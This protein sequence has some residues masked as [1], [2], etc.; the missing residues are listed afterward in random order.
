MRKS[1]KREAVLNFIGSKGTNGAKF[2][3]IQ[4]FIVEMN[5]K[6]YDE[7]TIATKWMARA[8]KYRGYWC[9]YLC[10]NNWGGY[11]KR[12]ILHEFCIKVSNKHYVLKSKIQSTYVQRYK[13]MAKENFND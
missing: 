13:E 11:K 6:N 7:F 2:S 9:D 12:G 8:R 1:P 5:G 10:G 4:R 3:E